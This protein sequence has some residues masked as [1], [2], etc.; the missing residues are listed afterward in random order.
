MAN[1]ATI[2]T[3]RDA[4]G[5]PQYSDTCP[6][7]EAC[8]VKRIGAGA[9]EQ[10]PGNGAKSS[11][12]NAAESSA[13]SDAGTVNENGN[14][15]LGDASPDA[16]TK[17][18]RDAISMGEVSVTGGGAS[19]AK[20]NS[21]GLHLAWQNLADTELAGYRVYYAPA[22]ASF[23]PPGQ[24]VNVGKATSFV[25]TGVTSGTRYYF[26][27]TAYDASGNERVS[28]NTVYKDVP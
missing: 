27:V 9:S 28:S 7:S 17:Q 16:N 23:Q 15:N 24:G 22:G 20:A 25:I 2:Y 14:A 1:A 19:D 12:H 13:D 26:K 18:N 11:Q 6:A 10:V 8:K 21:V 4:D 5:I 3:W